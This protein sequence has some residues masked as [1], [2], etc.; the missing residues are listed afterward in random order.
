MMNTEQYI[1]VI[2]GRIVEELGEQ[3]PD[4]DGVLQ[5]QLQQDL[6]PCHISNK[7]R[8][9][10]EEVMDWPGNSPDIA[11]IKNLWPIVERKLREIDIT[12][13]NNLI[14]VFLKVWNYNESVKK[15][16]KT[17]VCSISMILFWSIWP[18]KA[19]NFI[20][21]LHLSSIPKYSIYIKCS[22]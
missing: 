18:Y 1:K 21:L 13:Q 10:L 12:T 19:L 11:P 5:Q 9:H 3:F 7:M 17:L 22:D 2:D 4:G 20:L 8:K 6:I 14:L 15:V 16:C